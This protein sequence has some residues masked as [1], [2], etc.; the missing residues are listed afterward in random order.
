MNRA[1]NMPCVARE[2]LVAASS[3]QKKSPLKKLLH[4]K[5]MLRVMMTT[6]VRME[7]IRHATWLLTLTHLP[8]LPI[9]FAQYP[10]YLHRS[11]T[12]PHPYPPLHLR[13]HRSNSNSS[14]LPLSFRLAT[15]L[16]P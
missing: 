16:T 9:Q 2:G 1:T 8:S 13:L 11:H 12:R 10:L 7:M 15:G 3:L 14:H 5:P 4:L 6:S